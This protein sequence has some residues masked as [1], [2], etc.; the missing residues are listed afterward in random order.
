VLAGGKT[1]VGAEQPDVADG[2]YQL[3]TPEDQYSREQVCRAL[4]DTRVDLAA[5]IDNFGQWRVFQ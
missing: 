2:V 4:P 3:S 1:L 5:T